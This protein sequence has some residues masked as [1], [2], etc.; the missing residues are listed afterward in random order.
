MYIVQSSIDGR[1][2]FAKDSCPIFYWRI[3]KFHKSIW[4]MGKWGQKI[5]SF[6]LSLGV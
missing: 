5:L 4:R 3:Y 6:S 2:T 1:Q